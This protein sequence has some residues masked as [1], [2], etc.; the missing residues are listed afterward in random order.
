[1]PPTGRCAATEPSALLSLSPSLPAGHRNAR[2]ARRQ[3]APRRDEPPL[4]PP[5]RAARSRL[6]TP[7]GFASCRVRSL[8]QW[9]FFYVFLGV[10]FYQYLTPPVAQCATFQWPWMALIVARNVAFLWIWVGALHQLL[11]VCAR[12]PPH[13]PISREIPDR[14]LLLSGLAR[15]PC[16]HRRAPHTS[17]PQQHLSQETALFTAADKLKFNPSYPKKEQHYRD[18]LMSTSGALIDSGM[19][20]PLLSHFYLTFPCF[21]VTFYLVLPCFSVAFTLFLLI[22]RRP[23]RLHAPLRHGQDPLVHRFL[24]GAA[25]ESAPTCCEFRLKWPLF[26]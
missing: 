21:S 16:A 12:N 4:A 20:V 3:L 7:S 15:R 8:A 23:D 24:G 14:S 22:Y 5:A 19:Q 13:T 2:T 25:G 9:N 1:M 18:F 26:Q 17:D 10:F 6:L 11:Y